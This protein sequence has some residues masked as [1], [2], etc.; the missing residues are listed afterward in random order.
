MEL[1]V[2]EIVVLIGA[3]EMVGDDAGNLHRQFTGASAIKHVGQAVVEF[4]H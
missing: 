1:D 4:R 3:A 2:V